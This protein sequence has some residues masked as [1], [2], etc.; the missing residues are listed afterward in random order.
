MPIK[1]ILSK[2]LRGE[3]ARLLWIAILLA[4]TLLPILRL[5]HFVTTTGAN[6]PSNDDLMIVPIIDRVLSGTYHWGNIFSDTFLN[7]HFQLFPVL[8][9]ICLAYLTHW[10]IYAVLYFGIGLAVVKIVLLYN[11]ITYPRNGISNW[12]LWPVL[13]ALVFSASQISTFEFEF[14][15]ITKGLSELG[16]L[17]GLWGLVRFRG[18]VIGVLLMMVGGVFEGWSSGGALP[19]WICFLLGL[20]LLNYRRII[21]YVMWII[22]SILSLWPHFFYLIL[23]RSTD[24]YSLVEQ[25]SPEE[26]LKVI[27]FFNFSSIIKGIGLPFSQGLSLEMAYTRGLVGL[28]LF[29]VGLLIIW[30]ARKKNILFQLTPGLILIVYSLLTMWQISIFRPGLA[31]WYSRS[32]IFFWIGLLDLVYVIWTNRINK[33]SDEVIY[34]K[35]NWYLGLIWGLIFI[36]TL[37]YF[38]ATSNLSYEDKSFYLRSRRPASASCLRNYTTAPTYCEQTLFLW[39]PGQYSLLSQLG[40]PLQH[41]RLSVFG[42]NQIWTLQGDYILDN[43]HIH[44]TPGVPRVFWSTDLTSS[45]VPFSDY[46]HLNLFLHSPNSIEW[47][48]SLPTNLKRAE[49]HSAVAISSSAPNDPASD[50]AVFEVNL[51]QEGHSPELV[52]AQYVSADQRQWSPF[53]IPLTSFAGQIVTLRLSSSSRGNNMHDWTMYR[54]PYIDLTINP[55]EKLSDSSM[56]EIRPSNT[57]LSQSMTKPTNSDIVFDVTNTTLWKI[58]EMKSIQQGSNGQSSW[59][60][61]HDPE[62]EW[63]APLNVCLSDYTHLYFRMAASS[64]IYPRAAQLFLQIDGGGG[65]QR[66]V[67]VPLLADGQLHEYTYDLKLLELGQG[68]HLSGIRFNPLEKRGDAGESRVQIADLRLIRGDQPSVC[69]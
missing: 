67:Q 24:L 10:N 41:S 14:L 50:G 46:K 17:L 34:H 33:K 5:I 19:V 43:V 66:N 56:E 3:V 12:I 18:R 7:G 38:Y 65:S 68:D 47:T 40:A 2:I 23:R 29:F 55:S 16:I 59:F 11:L 58:K 62:M 54:Y 9:Q 6:N 15:A 64:N 31:Q 48:V 36:S 22:G 37:I 52:F 28:G 53:T 1:P 13:S 8:V 35:I 69:H 27:S 32:F 42:P 45:A 30:F 20:I 4:L 51:L 25:R 57:E 21:H 61:G 39:T 63:E 26:N 49:F 44:E 60:V